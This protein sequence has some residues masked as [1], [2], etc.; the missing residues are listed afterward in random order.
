MNL[1][2]TELEQRFLEAIMTEGTTEHEI[3]VD[4]LQ[5][6]GLAVTSAPAVAD[7]VHVLL[8][9]GLE[10]LHEEAA[11]IS[12]AAEAAAQNDAE[13]AVSAARHRRHV[14]SAVRAERG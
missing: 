6:A 13:R 3:Y 4:Y 5:R 14:E 12:Y 11:E 7:V 8:E 10:R 1:T 9:L 2:L